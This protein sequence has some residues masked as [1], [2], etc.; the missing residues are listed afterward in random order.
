MWE[1]VGGGLSPYTILQGLC[2]DKH[3]IINLLVLCIWAKAFAKTT[4]G[5]GGVEGPNMTLF[6]TCA[7][8]QV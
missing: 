7:V 3:V 4:S 6:K 2:V 8:F 1:D 5:K